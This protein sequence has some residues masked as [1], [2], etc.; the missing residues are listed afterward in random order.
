MRTGYTG[1]VRIMLQPGSE[2]IV[3]GKEWSK[4]PKIVPKKTSDLTHYLMEGVQFIPP[5]SISGAGKRETRGKL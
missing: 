3:C 2:Y 1:R 4:K 5:V